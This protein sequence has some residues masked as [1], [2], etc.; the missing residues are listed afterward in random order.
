MHSTFLLRYQEPI[1]FRSA[2][3]LGT[4]T[5][6]ESREQRVNSDAIDLLYKPEHENESTLR[7]TARGRHI[8]PCHQ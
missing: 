8:P 3:K 2:A 1:A 5:I 6:T 7:P 4:E